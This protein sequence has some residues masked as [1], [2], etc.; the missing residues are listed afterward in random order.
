MARRGWVSVAAL[1]VWALVGAIGV[2]AGAHGGT[3]PGSGSLYYLNDGFTGVANRVFTYGEFWDEVYFGDWNGDGVDTPMVRR[4]NTLYIRNSNSS[5]VADTVISYGNPGDEILTGDWNG[6]GVDTLAVRRNNTYYLKNSIST[7]VADVVITYGNPDDVVVVG[8]WDGSGTDTLTVRRGSVF[9]V[10]DTLTT[11]TADYAFT[12]GNPGDVVLVGDWDADGK[13]TLGVRRSTVNYLR[14]STTTGVADIVF[15]Y[16]NLTDVAFAGDWNADGRDTLGVRR[17]PVAPT[18]AAGWVGTDWETLRTSQRVVAL[19]FDGGA[20]D[21]GVSSILATLRRYG[22][23]ATFFPT[24]EFAR[25]YPNAVYAMAAAGHAVGNHSNTHPYF[26]SSTNEQIRAE[27]AAAD[28]SISALTGRTTK[29]LFRFP[30][31]DRTT[32]DIEVV[33]AAGYIPFR[34][35]VDTLGWEGTSGGITAAI[36]CRRVMDTARAGQIVLMH[37]GANPDDGTTLDADA[38]PCI[39]EGL[40]TRGYGFVTLRDFIN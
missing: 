14:N 37:V 7:G 34:W 15:S 18:A 1:G 35:T 3:V 4:G 11:G 26:S 28:A 32:L 30:Y 25:K 13:D 6:D 31:G 39:V 21:A 33:N 12:Y 17:A 22:V 5:G 19:T 38:L 10:R 23:A 27:L 24:G 20:S 9:H 8:D 29:P 36:V 16:G 40:R 2:P